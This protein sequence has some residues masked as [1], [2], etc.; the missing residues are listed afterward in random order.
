MTYDQAEQAVA[1]DLYHALTELAS[2][3]DLQIYCWSDAE[4]RYMYNLETK[5]PEYPLGSE[6][7]R[8][9]VDLHETF[10]DNTIL[11]KGQYNN[12]L[13]SVAIAMGITPKIETNTCLLAEEVFSNANTVALEQLLTYNRND[14]FILEEMIRKIT[15]NTDHVVDV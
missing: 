10:V 14:T 1:K 13:S 12:S 2:K 15:H 11:L 3:K 8:Y 9:L 4:A 7:A 6:F 5:Y